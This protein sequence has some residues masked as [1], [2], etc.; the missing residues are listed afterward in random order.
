LTDVVTFNHHTVVTVTCQRGLP[1]T[2][3]KIRFR[4]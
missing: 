2:P 3:E 1:V 4:P